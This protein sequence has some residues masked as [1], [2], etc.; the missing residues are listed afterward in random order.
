M[1]T[2][3]GAIVIHFNLVW[4]LASPASA[5]SDEHVRLIDVENALDEVWGW[6]HIN[7]NLCLGDRLVLLTLR[8]LCANFPKNRL[9]MGLPRIRRLLRL[10]RMISS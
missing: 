8:H 5:T 7:F 6:G 3:E 10:L 4:L 9:N 2:V 1:E